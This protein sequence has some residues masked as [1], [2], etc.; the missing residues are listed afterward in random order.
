MLKTA[1]EW[2]ACPRNFMKRRRMCGWPTCCSK[3]GNQVARDP[4]VL[5]AQ[6]DCGVHR[7]K[8]TKGPVTG[9]RLAVVRQYRVEPLDKHGLAHLKRKFPAPACFLNFGINAPLIPGAIHIFLLVFLNDGGSLS[10]SDAVPGIQVQLLKPVWC[11]FG[12]QGFAGAVKTSVQRGDN[13][14]VVVQRSL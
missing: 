13:N 2:A 8:K 9:F 10:S 1:H 7:G 12:L 6:Q 3:I 11:G 14:R 5:A 4:I